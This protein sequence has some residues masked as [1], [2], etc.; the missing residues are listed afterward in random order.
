M[1]IEHEDTKARRRAWSG[2]RIGGGC[3]VSFLFFAATL[4]AEVGG[5]RVWV[6][7]EKSG[8]VT[9]IDGHSQKAVQTIAAS[10]RPR[11][12]HAG[13]DGKFV[14]VALSGTAPEGPPGLRAK[15]VAPATEKKK[16]GRGGDGI[17][18]LDA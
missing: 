14:Y 15:P 5:Y 4:R 8:E 7:D 2:M 18:V 17:G 13:P 12:I 6:S 11:G 3:A 16:A 9:V 1:K 10:P